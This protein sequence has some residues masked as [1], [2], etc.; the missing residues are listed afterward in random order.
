MIGTSGIRL[1][2]D[3]QVD[4]SKSDNLILTSVIFITG[5]SGLSIQFGSIELSGMV[6]SSVVAVILSLMIYLLVGQPK[7]LYH[8]YQSSHKVKMLLHQ[9]H[10]P[11]W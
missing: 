1:L 3:Q 9:L 10:C 7:V 2:V 6:L 5:L 4:Y 11:G 8:L